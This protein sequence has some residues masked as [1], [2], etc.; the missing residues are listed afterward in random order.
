MKETKDLFQRIIEQQ[1]AADKFGFSWENIGQLLQQIR[2]EAD[3]VEIAAQTS[4]RAHL[5]E[6]IGDLMNAAV[7]LSFFCGFNPTETLAANIDKFQHRYNALVNFVTQD[8][9]ESLHKQP[10]DV[11]MHYW[12]RAKQ[13]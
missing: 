7:C 11:L 2:A 6:E 3:E 1:S 13:V 9:L 10:A 8:G 4:D 5:Q 12:N